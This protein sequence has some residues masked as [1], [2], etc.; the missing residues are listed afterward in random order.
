MGSR[1][2]GQ[3]A[4]DKG[5]KILTAT[6]SYNIALENDIIKQELLTYALIKMGFKRGK[7]TTSLK[8]GLSTSVSGYRIVSSA[9]QNF[10][11][12]Y[13]RERCRALEM[14]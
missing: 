7:P 3:L 11:K 10:M 1:G 4:F 9:C 5:M 2:L 14:V 12:K 8:T 6:Q 13:A